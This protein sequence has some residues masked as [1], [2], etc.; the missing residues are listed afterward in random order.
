[1]T[2]GPQGTDVLIGDAAE[3]WV[4]PTKLLNLSIDGALVGPGIV[5][6]TGHRIC[7]LFMK[8]PGAGWIDAEVVRAGGP[9]QVGIR[10]LSPLSAEII[11]A[12]TS[13][14]EARRDG[15]AEGETSDL[16]DGIPTR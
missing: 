3:D 12:A 16:G 14:G 9:G 11:R 1:M 15:D 7:L 2:P 6:A 13:D 4:I 5:I 10:F 8:I